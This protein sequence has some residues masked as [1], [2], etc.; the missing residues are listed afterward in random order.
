MRI[1]GQRKAEAMNGAPKVGQE[2]SRGQVKV[3]SPPRA[4]SPP[5]SRERPVSDAEREAR[6]IRTRW[7]RERG[8]KQ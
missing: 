8:E 7:L 3:V 4:I 5:R 2:E 6:E 1:S